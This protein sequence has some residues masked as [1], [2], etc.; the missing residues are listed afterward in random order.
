MEAKNGSLVKVH[1]TGKINGE[2]FDSSEGK[3]PLM[4]K[5]GDHRVIKGFEDAVIGMKKGD[6]KTVKISKEEGY[7]VRDEKLVS[8]IPKNQLGDLSKKVD[9]KPGVSFQLKDQM[10]NV[11]LA[12]VAEVKDDS[13]VLDLNHPL[14][15][16]DLT[17]DIEV[18]E[19]MEAK[20]K[21]EHESCECCE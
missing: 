5:V 19:V 8:E 15:G 10:G 20:G 13:I 16:K 9:L 21:D 12:T 14:A 18:V 3:E 17:F 11:A 6:K 2:V 4:F 1:Y 7:G